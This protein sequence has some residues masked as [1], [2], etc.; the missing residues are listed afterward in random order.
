MVFEHLSNPEIVFREFGRI[1]K[2]GGCLIFTTP[3]IYGI[4]TIVN[5]M[6]PNGLRKKLVNS[7]KGFERVCG[8]LRLY[9]FAERGVIPRESDKILLHNY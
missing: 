1:V 2:E 7:L 5:R 3:S 9:L 8:K 6:L 4:V